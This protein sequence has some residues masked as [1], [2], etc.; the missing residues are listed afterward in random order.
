M[1][2]LHNDLKN[3]I[4]SN[5]KLTYVNYVKNMVL[6]FTSQSTAMVMSGREIESVSILSVRVHACVLGGGGVNGCYTSRH[7][8]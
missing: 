7:R 8:V 4:N 6:C 5:H 1:N 3:L 2:E